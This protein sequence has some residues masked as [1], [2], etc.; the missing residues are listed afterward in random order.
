MRSQASVGGVALVAVGAGFAW[1]FLARFRPPLTLLAEVG[2]PAATAVIVLLA[3]L[4]AGVA[5]ITI[6]RRI[7]GLSAGAPVPVADSLLIGDPVF[8]TVIG[9]VAW[10]SMAPVIPVPLAVAP[11][12]RCVPLPGTY[13]SRARGSPAI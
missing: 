12:G 10:F 5:A 11:C 4:A 8:G 13:V 9:A 1:V 2:R 7:F 6:A 3:A